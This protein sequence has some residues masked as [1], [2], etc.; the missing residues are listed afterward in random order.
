MKAGKAMRDA[1]KARNRRLSTFIPGV[2]LRN[3]CIYLLLV[4]FLYIPEGVNEVL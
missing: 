2:K 4:F 1:E 3:S